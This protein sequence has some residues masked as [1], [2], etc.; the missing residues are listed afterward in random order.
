MG[1]GKYGQVVKVKHRLTNKVYGMKMILKSHLSSN[2][3]TKLL[4][5]SELSVLQKIEHRNLMK[6]IEVIE[7]EKNFYLICEFAEGGTLRD[8]LE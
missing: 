8:R 4:F 2:N 3:T 1:Q 6:F 5:L 7:D